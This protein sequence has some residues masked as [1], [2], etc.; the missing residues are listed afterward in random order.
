MKVTAKNLNFSNANTK[1]LIFNELFPIGAEVTL[2]TVRR[3]SAA[4]LSLRCAASQ[5]MST[6]QLARF[7]RRANRL[8][9]DYLKATR[10]T[11]AALRELNPF[12]D[13]LAWIEADAAHEDAKQKEW[14][15]YMD[16]LAVAFVYAADS[17]A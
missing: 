9:V 15:T 11:L 7:S 13:K 2:G 1:R 4:G 5:L 17:E 16:G 6:D 12:S 10:A 3:A 8:L 14:P